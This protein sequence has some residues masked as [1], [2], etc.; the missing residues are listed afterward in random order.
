MW[1]SGGRKWRLRGPATVGGC[2]GW[3]RAAERTANM[4]NMFVTLDVSKLTG[5]LKAVA[6]CRVE[7]RACDAGRGVRA[8]RR[9]S[10]GAWGSGGRKGRARGR[11]ATV[12]GCGGRARAVK[13]TMN[14][15]TMSVTLDVSKLTGWLK[16]FAPCRGRKQGV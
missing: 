2:G 11:P 15:V 9:G 3:A 8:G 6:N 12:G 4:S 5:W 13:R 1:G 10:Y 16:A 7:S 14:M